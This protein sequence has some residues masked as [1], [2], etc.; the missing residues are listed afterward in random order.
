MWISTTEKNTQNF[1]TT[2]FSQLM[3]TEIERSIAQELR[4]RTEN[5]FASAMPLLRSESL[6]TK[7]SARWDFCRRGAFD[8]SLLFFALRLQIRFQISE[9]LQ[10]LKSS[11]NLTFLLI[12]L[13]KI[14]FSFLT[15]FSEQRRPNRW[16]QKLLHRRKLQNSN[17]RRI[18]HLSATR[19][20]QNF[21]YERKMLRHLPRATRLCC[22]KR[23]LP[24]QVISQYV[25][26]F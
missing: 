15:L 18:F 8:A 7:I 24:D 21:A 26:V 2:Q 25:I 20:R 19:Q 23:M 4:N 9:I 10:H 6:S 14:L 3:S 11:S 22:Y 12:N 1:H 16:R 5:T 13:N 17:W